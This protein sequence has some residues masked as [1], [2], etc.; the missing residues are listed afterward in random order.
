MDCL[1]HATDVTSGSIINSAIVESKVH[2]ID[3]LLNVRVLV[4]SHLGL[5]R[6]EVHG[7]LNYGAV[8]V[9]AQRDGV[10]WSKFS[11]GTLSHHMFDLA[12]FAHAWAPLE[13]RWEVGGERASYADRYA[14]YHIR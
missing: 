8:V 10:D 2:V 9:E 5:N 12:T 1:T 4:L 7:L 14:G 13:R 6:L 11:Q 3:E